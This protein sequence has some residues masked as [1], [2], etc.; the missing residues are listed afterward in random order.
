MS[1]IVG[2][3]ILAIWLIFTVASQS[4]GVD[5]DL[6]E[7]GTY[8]PLVFGY[9]KIFHISRKAATAL[10]IIPTIG[11]CLAFMFILTKHIT[12]MAS[13]G[14]LPPFLKKT[15]GPNNF[16]LYAHILVAVATLGENFFAQ[17][18][19]VS[20]FSTRTATVAGCFV[21]LAMFYC[22]YIFNRRFGH[23][24][25][26]FTNPLGMWAAVLG[27]LIFLG[28]LIILVFFHLEYK[29]AIIFYFAYIVLMLIFYYCYVEANQFFSTNEQKVF[30]RAY[31]INCKS[32][33]RWSLLSLFFIFCLT[34]AK[35]KAEIT[36]T[37]NSL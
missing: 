23:M 35:S 24:E 19:A 20:T 15:V 14:L 36:W 5:T 7:K 1:L 37:E 27:S 21:Y 16:P 29:A 22:Y 30:F 4:P 2:L 12:A 8:F 11:T 33:V 6:Y 32:I 13:S 3:L 25:R 18:V 28:I 10:C 31:I 26:Q 9:M 34:S 17:A